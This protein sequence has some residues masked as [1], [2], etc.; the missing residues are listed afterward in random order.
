VAKLRAQARQLRAPVCLQEVRAP[1][2]DLN[3]SS[4]YPQAVS[5]TSPG[6]GNIWRRA[7]LTHNLGVSYRLRPNMTL[8]ANANNFT[9]N[10]PEL[11]TY[12]ASRPRQLLISPTF[13]KFGL[14]GQF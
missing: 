12:I 8:F 5:L 4:A 13:I 1:S 10:G 7:L 2:Y 11:Y 3:Y 9:E 6:N 14:S